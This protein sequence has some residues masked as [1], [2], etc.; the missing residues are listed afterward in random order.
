MGECEEIDDYPVT[1]DCGYEGFRFDCSRG[2]CPN[3]GDKVIRKKERGD[4][5][6]KE[7]IAKNT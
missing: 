7:K 5:T 6:N 1:C 2:C 3:C 4:D